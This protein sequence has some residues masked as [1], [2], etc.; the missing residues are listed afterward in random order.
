MKVN[1]STVRDAD[2]LREEMYEK[3]KKSVSLDILRKGKTQSVTLKVEARED[4]EENW[5]DEDDDQSYY[6]GGPALPQATHAA[7]RHA[8]ADANKTF[9][10]E[11]H[12]TLSL[13]NQ[14]IREKMER[15]H[16]RISEKVLDL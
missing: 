12:E 8:L 16:Q 7:A 10:R 14:R 1:S 6:F 3:D 11:L 13:M 2:D 4:D 15:L 9:L 5:N